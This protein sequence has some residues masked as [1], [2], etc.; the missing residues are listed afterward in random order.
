MLVTQLGLNGAMSRSRFKK[1]SQV[2]IK[3][4][5][6]RQLV[7]QMAACKSVK[8]KVLQ[9]L[10]SLKLLASNSGLVFNMSPKLK[11]SALVLTVIHDLINDP[12]H[13]VQGPHEVWGGERDL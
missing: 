10:D 8:L 4:L 13:K 9:T 12:Q 7:S 1:Q 11:R 3:R 6:E 5:H 2:E